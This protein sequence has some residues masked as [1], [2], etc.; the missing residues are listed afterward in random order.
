MYERLK[1]FLAHASEDK[2]LV[3]EIYLKLVSSG[4]KLWLDEEDL[5]AGQN[6][7]IEIPKAIRQSDIFIACLS[8][9][10]V[11]KQGYVQRELR[12]ALDAYAEKPADTIYLIPLKLDDCEIPDLQLPSLGIRLRDVS[13]Q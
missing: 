8:Q 2:K 7:R 4:F 9:R 1:I 6:W 10:F 13:A 12:L 11:Q 5:V 3:R